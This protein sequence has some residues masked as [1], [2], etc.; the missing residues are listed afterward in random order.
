MYIYCTASKLC[1][2]RQTFGFI[3]CQYSNI[4]VKIDL[5]EMSEIV[6]SSLSLVF[7]HDPF[8]MSSIYQNN[9]A[10]ISNARIILDL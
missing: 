1:T 7:V 5:G 4:L 3:D 10:V 9:G 2:E 6:I 8:I